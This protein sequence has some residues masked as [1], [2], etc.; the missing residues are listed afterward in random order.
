MSICIYL[1]YPKYK[2]EYFSWDAYSLSYSFFAS[3]FFLVFAAKEGL[4]TIV[5]YTLDQSP[6]SILYRIYP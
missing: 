5:L 6:P 3:M 4:L 2:N 1:K